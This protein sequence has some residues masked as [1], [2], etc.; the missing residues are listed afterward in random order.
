[1]KKAITFFT[2]L[3]ILIAFTGCDM[4]LET[5][6][7][8]EKMGDGPNNTI[9]VF[10]KVNQ[11]ILD[12]AE[13]KNAPRINVR[14]LKHDGAGYNDHFGEGEVWDIWHDWESRSFAFSYL[15]PGSYQV[16]VYWDKNWNW[17]VDGGEPNALAFDW[18]TSYNYVDIPENAPQEGNYYEMDGQL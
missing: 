13:Y 9:N 4:I 15:P 11:N 17:Q 12:Q 1:M 10:I 7:P 14:L 5:L 8:D 6:Y 3:L 16:V 2:T 18:N